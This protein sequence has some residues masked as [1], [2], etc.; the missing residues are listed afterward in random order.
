MTAFRIHHPKSDIE[1]LYLPRAQGGRGLMQLE[2]FYKI[3]TV[4]LQEYLVKKNGKLIQ[5]S[6]KHEQHKKLFSVFK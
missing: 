4:G 3:S 5:I 6:T 1:R 2:N